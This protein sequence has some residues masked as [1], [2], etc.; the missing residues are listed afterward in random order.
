MGKL[1]D[2]VQSHHRALAIKPDYT[3]AHNNIAVALQDLGKLDEAAAYYHK[4]LAINS[5]YVEAHNNLGKLFIE[6]GKLE[7]AVASYRTALAI[8]P[9]HVEARKNFG[10]LQ[11]FMGDFQNGW[12]NYNFRWLCDDYAPGY[13]TYG[14]PLWQGAAIDG[15]SLLVYEEQGVGETILFASMIP[16]LIERGADVIFECDKRLILPFSRSFPSITCVAKDD[17]DI[18]NAED[19][20]FDLH[21]PLGNGARWLRADLTSFSTRPSYLVADSRQRQ[22]IRK[23]YLERGNDLLVGISWHSQSP[24]Y[25][26]QKSMTLDGL[27]PLLEVTGITFVNLQYGDTC[28]ERKAFTTETGIEIFHDNGIDPMDDLDMFTSQVAAM[29]MVV[30]ISNTTAHIAGA[31]GVPTLLLLGTVPIWYWLLEREDSPWYPSLHLFRQKERG[32]WQ[33]VV[34]RARNELAVLVGDR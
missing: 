14:T 29:D 31:L 23:R 30:T 26:Q 27:R 12:E 3:E 5:D 11:L 16:D 13:K 32:N 9:D 33:G 6:L 24:H 1:E 2:A 19:K 34:E 18:G 21:V 28:E 7:E 22:T 10:M 20:M 8:K 17:P 25:G 4:A 15:K